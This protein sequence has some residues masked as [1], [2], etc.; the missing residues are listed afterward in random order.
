MWSLN[1]GRASSEGAEFDEEWQVF[2]AK[3]KATK[4]NGAQRNVRLR[5]EDNVKL[6]SEE[7]KTGH[8]PR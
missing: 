6:G 4:T 8:P 3:K 1:V 2:N 7:L 5:V